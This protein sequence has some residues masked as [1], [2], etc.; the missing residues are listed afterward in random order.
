MMKQFLN[1]IFGE[2]P[3][4][5]RRLTIFTTPDK[6]AGHF[7]SIEE[8][9][10]YARLRSNTQNVYFGLSLVS[11]TPRGRGT[12]DDTAAIGALWADIDIAGSVHTRSD[13]PVSIEQ[14]CELLNAL[15]IPPSYVIDSGHGLH[16]YWLLKEPWIFE[17]AEERA[18]AVRL[19]RGWHGTVCAAAA[20]RGW[21]LENLGDLTR[22][23]R[24]PDTI[25]H[26]GA[27]TSVRLLERWPERRY[28][29]DDFEPYLALT[30]DSPAT[31]DVDELRLD[32]A[33]EPPA[34]KLAEALVECPQ[35]KQS[36]LRE[37]PDLADQSPSGY[38]LSLAT[39]AA[40]RG[41]SDQEIADL[42]ITARR[43]HG[44]NPAKA[45]RPDYI[46]RTLARARVAAQATTTEVNLSALI[47]PVDPAPEVSHSPPDPGPLPDHLLR[48]PGFI[49]EVMDHTLDTAPYPNPVMAFCGAVALQAHLAGRKVRDGGDN[50]TN[51]YLLGLAHSAAG[52]D[53][54]RKINTRILHQVGL[55]DGLGERFASGEG[56]QDALFLQP[57][58][59]FQTDEIDGLLQSI[60]KAKDARHES[61]MSTLLTIYSAANS[62][63]PMRRKAGKESPGAIDQ[64]CL[65]IFGTAIPTH[66]Y[67]ALSER[68]LTNGFF[69]RMIILESGP[70]PAGQEPRISEL[71]ERVLDT[72]HWW[73]EFKPGRGNLEKWHPVPVVIEHT[74]QAQQLLVEV[75]LEADQH[76]A[77]AEAAADEVGTT[78]WGRVSE[79]IRKLALIYA[80]SE[81]HAEP[82][83]H[84]AAVTWA[85]QFVMHQTRRMLF[86]AQGHVADNPFHAECLKFLKKLADAPDQMLPHSKLLKRMKVDLQAFQKIV[87]TLLQQ[88]DIEPVAVATTG[89]TGTWYRLINIVNTGGEGR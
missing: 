79:Q 84:E 28:S 29:P 4:A 19:T 52:K 56:V 2:A 6:R 39:I 48:I 23:L 76:Y 17:T 41:W 63:F 67:Q 72:A 49:S 34:L 33:A 82:L 13:L 60:N 31:V 11:G 32:P 26:N 30:D 68:M 80:V 75:R 81:N 16:A 27:P 65:V 35:F 1:D 14:A 25:N 61:V 73:S 22:V 51:L 36:W 42:V 55:D 66:Y 53:W 89:R 78:V 24:L 15:P 5:Q 21:F 8:A 50:R 43:Q 58:M 7:A 74:H 87:E 88:G 37:R 77:A 38:D 71:P 47:E 45:L 69:A 57:A 10:Q 59:L 64:P 70:R 62:V 20:T 44:H 85:R 86:M 40:L 9:E 12:F 46:Q 3:S 54:P 18:R 83:I